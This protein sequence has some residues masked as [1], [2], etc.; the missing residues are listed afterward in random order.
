MGADYA[1]ARVKPRSLG[2]PAVAGQVLRWNSVDLTSRKFF[3]FKVTF[4]VD[5]CAPAQLAFNAG[6]AGGTCTVNAEPEVTNVKRSK[7]SNTC[8]PTRAPTIAPT[9][10]PT[11]CSINEVL[12][13]NLC[14]Y[15]DGSGGV[16]DTGY[17]LGTN[18]QLAAVASLFAGKNYL[19]S[20]SDNCCIWTS[21]EF[22]NYGMN[23]PPSGSCNQPGP[24]LIGEPVFNGAFCAG[25]DIRQP[26]QLTFCVTSV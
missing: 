25:A 20:V 1:S 6:V 21:D 8:A 12:F 14:Y 10:A 26:M 15:L 17:A 9:I 3:T 7:E 19:R 23:F 5:N 18:A 16:C 22:Q 11:K 24:F 13:D 2:S 4:D